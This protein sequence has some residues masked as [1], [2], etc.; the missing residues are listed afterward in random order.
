MDSPDAA[1]VR[2][3]L[4]RL[5]VWRNFRGRKLR[6]LLDFLVEE[7]LADRKEKLTLSYIG[8]SVNDEPLTFEEDS[9]RW[10]Y[11]KT[12]ANLAHV[13]KRLMLFNE[14]DGYND[15]V[16]IK[17]NLG[18]FVPEIRR[19]PRITRMA[20]VGRENENLIAR[21]KLAIDRRT[22]WGALRAMK[23]SAQLGSLTG[24]PRLTATYVFIQA[25][26]ASSVPTSFGELLGFLQDM[27]PLMRA[28]QVQPWE[29]DF[30]E[31][32]VKAA[33]EHAWE[34]SLAMFETAATNS[35]GEAVYFWWYTA[36]LACTGMLERAIDLLDSAVR[37]FART[38][39]A[40]RTD[41]AMIQIMAGHYTDAE[42]ILAASL[43]LPAGD[44]PLTA[45][46]FAVLYEAQDRLFEAE[47]VAWKW[48]E[49]L[50]TADDSL[51][52]EQVLHQID[53]HWGL[54]GM[55]ILSAARA[56]NSGYAQRYL[57]VLFVWKE[58]S[59][60]ASSCVE[61]AIALVGL[62]RYDEAVKWLER[63]AFEEHDPFTMWFHIFPPLRHLS[64]HRGYLD[65]LIRLNLPLQRKR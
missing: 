60:R 33:Y 49:K 1:E 24:N 16:I 53:M 8:E 21:V 64:S 11:P 38:N 4:E 52:G 5:H 7:W 26:L 42:E 51:S 19:N 58:Q 44:N 14:T 9:D 6:R 25:V 12:R 45:F 22:Y 28:E 54:M 13:R 50:G 15:K 3:Q 17:L 29:C 31:A 61:I 59:S 36:L 57:N 30:A 46:H 27:I 41:L 18:S 56:G 20:P 39:L 47:E 2:A 62:G 63:A 32:C 23:Y 43:D 10:S 37:H 65:L 40:T 48:L 55:F 35:Q 34:D